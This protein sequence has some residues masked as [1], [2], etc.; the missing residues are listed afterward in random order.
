LL[1]SRFDCRRECRRPPGADADARTEAD[2]IAQG[3]APPA[4]IALVVLLLAGAGALLVAA[5]AGSSSSSGRSKTITGGSF[6]SSIDAGWTVRSRTAGSG[7]VAFSLSST[8]APLDAAGVPP[9]GELG[10]T[11]SETPASTL[12]G[13]APEATATNPQTRTADAIALLSAVVRTPAAAKD[14][15]V[16]QPVRFKTLAGASAAEVAYEYSYRGHGSIQVDV[17]ARRHGRIYFVELDTEVA[18]MSQG[19]AALARLLAR[20]RW[21]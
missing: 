20:W 13:L 15:A 21:R 12:T 18:R 14:V 2:L 1:H 16:T 9:A 19:E 7:A 11:V 6:Q 4:R 8:R 17:V 5:F 10:I 3:G